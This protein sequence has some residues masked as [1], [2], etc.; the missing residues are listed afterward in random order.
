VKAKLK[1]AE[2]GKKKIWEKL[3]RLEKYQRRIW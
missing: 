1:V 3:Q 2:S